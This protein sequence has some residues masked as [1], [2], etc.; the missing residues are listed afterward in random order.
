MMERELKIKLKKVRDNAIVPTYAK[1]GD[2]GC[3]LYS[4]EE[5]ILEPGDSCIVHT[6]I[7]VE[8]PE[9][10]E[11]QIRS[12]SGKAI[13]EGLVVINSPGTIDSGYRDEIK[14]GIIN[15][16]RN[17]SYIGIGDR[18]AQ[19]V[20]CPVYRAVFEEVDTLSDSA[21]GFGGLGHTDIEQ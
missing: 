7:A 15:L 20:I 19:L 16:G 4:L 13:K 2:A 10:Y 11:G 14:V 21:R 3:D 6:G 17:I 1:P 8:L 9:G 5:F 18:I 12:R